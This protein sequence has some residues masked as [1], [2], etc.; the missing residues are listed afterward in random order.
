M[1]KNLF[2]CGSLLIAFFPLQPFSMFCTQTNKN[3]QVLISFTNTYQ[4]LIALENYVGFLIGY[5]ILNTNNFL[6]GDVI[7]G[8]KNRKISLFSPVLYK[9]PVLSGIE[10]EFTIM[11]LYGGMRVSENPPILR[12]F[13]QCSVLQLDC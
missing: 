11:A 4:L 8:K 9:W 12:Y 13:I 3:F 7:S 10:T 6:F 1:I 5:L 2:R